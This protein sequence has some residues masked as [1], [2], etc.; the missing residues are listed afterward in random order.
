MKMQTFFR[1][2]SKLEPFRIFSVEHVVTLGIIFALC[3]F[4]VVKKSELELKMKRRYFRITLALLLLR[5]TASLACIRACMVF[6][7]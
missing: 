2:H 4:F 3:I 7:K 1:Y 5:D 6:K